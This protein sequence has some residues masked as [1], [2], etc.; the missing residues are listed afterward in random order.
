MGRW[1]R[2]LLALMLLL[3]VIVGAALYTHV[4]QPVTFA[5][6]LLSFEL[7]PGTNLRSAARELHA[8]GVLPAP[9]VFELLARLR[10]DTPHLKA[11]NYEIASPISPLALLRKL[12]RGDATLTVVRFIEGWTFQQVRQALDAHDA[13]KHDTR[14]LDDAAIARELGLPEGSI[15]GWIFPD[16]YFFARG[17]SDLAVLRRAHVLMRKHLNSLWEAREPQLPLRSPYEALILASIIEKETG[18]AGDRGLISAVFTN[19]LR[20]GMRLQTDPTVIYGMG[21]AFDGNLRR[22]DLQADTPWNTYTREGLP[23]TPIAMPGLASLK[24]ALNPEESDMLYFVARGDGTSKFSRTLEEHNAAVN[25]YQRAPSR[26][27]RK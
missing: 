22:R 7:K 5:P 1:I 16:S 13:I 12:T 18:R 26:A 2:R 27:V 9:F 14:G 4:R 21:S 19:R 10:G 25:R 3:A 8:L 11:G 15:E 6:A 20:R 24:A 17:S 23:P